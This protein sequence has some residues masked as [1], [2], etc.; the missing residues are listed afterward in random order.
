MADKR[1]GLYGTKAF[2]ALAVD[3]YDRTMLWAVLHM[4]PEMDGLMKPV[5]WR[6]LAVFLLP[7]LLLVFVRK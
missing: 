1:S 3:E 4:S 2:S 7:V 5:S 6:S